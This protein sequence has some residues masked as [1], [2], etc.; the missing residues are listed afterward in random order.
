MLAPTHVPLLP[1]VACAGLAS[2]FGFGDA[3]M[4]SSPV[5]NGQS[6][7][8]G[9]GY[10]RVRCVVMQQQQ[11]QPLQPKQ[12]SAVEGDM[13]MNGKRWTWLK[14]SKSCRLLGG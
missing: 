3:Q 4:S 13:E 14:S 9:D 11:R 10:A 5:V 8:H 7:W 1:F 6:G 12:K 2:A